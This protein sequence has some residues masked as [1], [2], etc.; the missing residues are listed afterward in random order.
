MGDE[1]SMTDH[2]V[3]WK[4]SGGTPQ[5]RRSIVLALKAYSKAKQS[6]GWRAYYATLAALVESGDIDLGEAWG[7]P[8][9]REMPF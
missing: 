2:F 8:H 9:E 6:P 7:M 3:Y 5:H 4:L 1:V